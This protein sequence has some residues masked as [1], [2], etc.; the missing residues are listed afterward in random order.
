M[1]EK[2]ITLSIV[3]SRRT[4]RE[5][6]R[7]IPAEAILQKEKR[8]RQKRLMSPGKRKVLKRSLLPAGNR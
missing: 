1:A 7:L 2:Q 5:S 8:Q 3:T 4:I 6:G